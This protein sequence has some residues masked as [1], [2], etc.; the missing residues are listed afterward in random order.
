MIRR[1]PR[2]TLFPYT[3]LFRSINFITCHDGFTLQDLVSYNEKHNQT[4]GE[5]NKDGTGENLSWNCGV[6]GPAD[7][8]EVLKLRRRQK[9]NFLAALILSQGVPMLLAG[10]E[11][12]RTQRGNNNAYCQDNEISWVN[13][14]IG[15][16]EQELLEFTKYLIKTTYR[17]PALRRRKFF[18]GRK[19]RGSKVKDLIWL[20]PDGGEMTD[21]DWSMP[22][23]HCLGLRIAGDEIDEVDERG[24]KVVDDT[25]LLLLNAYDKTV[26]FILPG[27]A[28]KA[29]WRLILDTQ[30]ADGRSGELLLKAGIEPY[31]LAARS[32][33]LL[34]LRKAGGKIC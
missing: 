21:N 23:A 28:V 14:D 13:W 34:C 20:K 11:F 15:Q 30:V 25:L 22:W 19:I 32:L 3:T 27:S 9:R 2:S 26:S 1:P 6:E 12:G 33:V 5:E 31:R 24:N 29:Q 18:H 10:D 17:H 8:A 7:D 4:N 16:P